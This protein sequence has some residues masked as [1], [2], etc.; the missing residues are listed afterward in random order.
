MPDE[1]PV[2]TASLRMLSV[3]MGVVLQVERLP[4]ASL[5]PSTG[6]HPAGA[7]ASAAARS[8]HR[9][10]AHGAYPASQELHTDV[11]DLVTVPIETA[12]A[13]S[14]WS[15]VATWWR[16]NACRRGGTPSGWTSCRA[17]CP[18]SCRRHPP[19]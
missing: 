12:C 16:A 14:A 3:A 10:R 2:M 17:R 15:C 8:R 5:V 18:T 19:C 6:R 9:A 13:A 4:D 7:T 11:D 1:A